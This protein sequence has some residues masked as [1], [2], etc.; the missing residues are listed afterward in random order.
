ML[1]SM[2]LQEGA[3]IT[4]DADNGRVYAGRLPLVRERP[5]AALDQVAKWRDSVRRVP[6]AR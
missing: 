6:V 3:A 2:R 1:G 4:L 5:Q